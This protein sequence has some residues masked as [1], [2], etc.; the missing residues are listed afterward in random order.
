MSARREAL[1]PAALFL[2]SALPIVAGLGHIGSLDA[3]VEADARFVP[4][5]VSIVAHVLAVT[6]YS[7]LGALQFWPGF[8]RRFPAWHRRVGRLL[9]AAGLVAALTG[10]GM[11][12]ASPIPRAHQGPILEAARIAVAL[13]MLVAL[14]LG[15][16]RIRQRDVAAH[17]AWM[18]RAYAL[19]LGAATQVLVLAPPMIVLG[20]LEG[21]P[22]DL[23]MSL[24]WAINAGLAEWLVRRRG[25]SP[26][27]AVMA[28]AA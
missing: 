27:S 26:G 22:R 5:P 10:L 28:G 17:E 20:E 23:L 13:G 1:V 7:L 3:S 2:L 21:L 11:A 24:S 6:P 18:I 25:P 16:V 12:V 8:R 9:V 14:V 4:I 19:G 15:L